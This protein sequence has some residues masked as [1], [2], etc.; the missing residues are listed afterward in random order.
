MA[1]ARGNI[2]ASHTWSKDHPR[3]EKF[4]DGPGGLILKGPSVA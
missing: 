2:C 1:V 3:P 4:P